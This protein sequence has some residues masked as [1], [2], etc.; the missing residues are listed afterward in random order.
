MMTGDTL[1]A[2]RISKAF[3]HQV[4]VADVTLIMYINYN[5]IMWRTVNA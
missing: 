1:Y 5:T 4:V 2:N 3:F